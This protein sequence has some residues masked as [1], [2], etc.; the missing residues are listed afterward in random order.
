MLYYSTIE[1]VGR[2]AI[3]LQDRDV[4]KRKG[5]LA[6]VAYCRAPKARVVSTYYNTRFLFIVVI[7]C[8][9]RVHF[10]INSYCTLVY[11]I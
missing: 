2:Y 8:Y 1:I 5:P 9:I 3:S 4:L 11:V 7:S 6:L 10:N